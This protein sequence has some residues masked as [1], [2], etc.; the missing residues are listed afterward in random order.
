[1][2]LFSFCRIEF[3]IIGIIAVTY[4]FPIITAVCFGEYSQLPAFIIPMLAAIVIAAIFIMTG[5][6][7]KIALSTRDAFVVVAFAW[8]LASLFGALPFLFSGVFPSVTDAIWESVSGFSTTGATVLGEV[9]SLP[10]SINL[11]RTETHWLGGMGIVALTVALFPLLGVGGFQLIKAETTGPEKGKVT[12]KI[13][14]TAKALWLIYIV[15]TCL[16]IIILKIAGMN[17]FDA[18]LH[19]FSTVGTGGFS[20]KNASIGAYNSAAIDIIIT[21][22]MFLAGVNFSLY[23]YLLTGKFSDIRHNSELKAYLAIIFS[24]VLFMTFANTGFYGNFFTSLRFSAFQTAAIISTS[25]FATADYTFWTPAAQTFILL[26]FFTGGC[27]GSTSGGIKVIRWVIMGKQAN[28]EIQRMLHPHG[29]FSIRLN[30][31]VGRKDIVFNVAAFLMIYAILVVLTTI[32]GTIAKLDVL[33][34]FTGALSMVG[35]V[36]PGFGLLGPSC[37]YGFLPA[38]LKWWY[39]FAMLA[40]R[41]ELYTMIIFFIPEFWKK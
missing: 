6:K 34:A 4:I 26:L 13:T 5:R 31:R 3:S 1:M 41:L 17:F 20:N 15:F 30:N 35:N 9:E 7:K 21:V 27:S 22:F 8:I 24:F 10:N 36:G 32:F 40:G 18:V 2:S 14:N 39:M 19:A 29:V 37:N 38:A 28:N 16:E 11:W 12:P 25:G 23:F 33:S